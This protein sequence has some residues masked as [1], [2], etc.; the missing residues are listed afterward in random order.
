VLQQF[1]FIE[2][3][4]NI[5]AD[6]G[7][8]G[9]LQ[10]F[11]RLIIAVKMNPFGR[12][13]CGQGRIQFSAGDHIQRQPFFLRQLAHGHRIEGL[14]RIS[15]LCPHAFFPKGTHKLAASVSNIRL[16]VYKQR[17]SVFLCKAN[18]VYPA[19]FQMTSFVRATRSVQIHVSSLPFQVHDHLE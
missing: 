2:I 17:G 8:K 13:R 12:K 18:G 1:Q 4:H 3:V 5:T 14:A 6:V 9:H 16:V 7:L 19:D 11:W 10:L 15:D